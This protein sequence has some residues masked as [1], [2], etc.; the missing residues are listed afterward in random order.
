MNIECPRCGEIM[1]EVDD[2]L[3]LECPN[4]GLTGLSDVDLDGSV[5]CNTCE[6]DEKPF[7]CQTCGGPYPD[8]ISSCNI[9]DDA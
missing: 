7:C 2:I 6:S 9:F 8:C 5:F 3:D 1:N 4:C